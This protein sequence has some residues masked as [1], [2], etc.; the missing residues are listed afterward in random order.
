MGGY[1]APSPAQPE[2]SAP[3]ARDPRLL[4]G[5]GIA[6]AVVAVA[7]AYLFL[8][9]GGGGTASPS[10]VPPGLHHTVAPT[11]TASIVPV[12]KPTPTVKAFKGDV[13]RDPFRALITSAPPVA[14]A[15]TVA[16]PTSTVAPVTTTPSPGS[17]VG[18]SGVPTGLPV[19]TPPTSTTPATAIPTTT[20]P[21]TKVMVVLKAIAFHGTTPYVVVTYSG[22]Q[23]AMTTGES[24]GASLKV[25]AIAPDDGTATFQLG[26]QTF[27]LH[28]GQSYVD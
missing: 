27:D 23:Y 6:L 12:A 8:S 2:D 20:A 1:G 19:G 25:V 15:T 18:P 13:G 4:I 22:V 14:A 10:A 24:A 17:I 9:G 21:P 26:D 16:K 28:I 3:P 7:G 5:G 11:T